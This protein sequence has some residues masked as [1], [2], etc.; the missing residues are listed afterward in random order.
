MVCVCLSL[1]C[2]CLS[3][4]TNFGGRQASVHYLLLL[5]HFM[6]CASMAPSTGII[7]ISFDLEPILVG[8][9]RLFRQSKD[10][11]GQRAACNNMIKSRTLNILQIIWNSKKACITLD[12]SIKNGILERRRKE[13]WSFVKTWGCWSHQGEMSKTRADWYVNR[14]CKIQKY[15][16]LEINIIWSFVLFKVDKSF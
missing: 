16:N 13:K 4:L 12:I 14:N 8:A 3:L 9:V 11:D 10:R 1:L 2:L 5:L 7:W 15:Q 6:T